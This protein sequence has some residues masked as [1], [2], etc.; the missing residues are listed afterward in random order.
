MPCKP[1]LSLEL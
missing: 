1:Y